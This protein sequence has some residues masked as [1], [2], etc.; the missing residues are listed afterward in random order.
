MYAHRVL[1]NSLVVRIQRSKQRDATFFLILVVGVTSLEDVERLVATRVLLDTDSVT[2]LGKLNLLL[3]RKGRIGRLLVC[4]AAVGGLLREGSLGEGRVLIRQVDLRVSAN[5]G[6]RLVFLTTERGSLTLVVRLRGSTMGVALH[7]TSV[8]VPRSLLR[9][10]VRRGRGGLGFG[11]FRGSEQ[12]DALLATWGVV[13]SGGAALLR[14]A[15]VLVVGCERRVGRLLVR[16]GRGAL[17]VLGRRLVGG[18]GVEGRVGAILVSLSTVSV[19]LLGR[20][21]VLLPA[22]RMCGRRVVHSS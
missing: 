5:H 2:L 3:A 14:L 15:V 10:G 9:W 6:S 17:R 20:R 1:P 19:Y 12:V 13:E 21:S 22:E 4:L 8:G 16:L 7:G 18:V 11:R